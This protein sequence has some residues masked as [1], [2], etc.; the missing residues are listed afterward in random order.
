MAKRRTRAQLEALDQQIMDVCRKDHPVSVRHVFYR[1]TDP[2]LPEPVEKSG[3]GYRSVQRRVTALRRSGRLPYGWIADATRIGWHVPTFADPD[4]FVRAYASAYR[5]DLW[6]SHAPTV[7]VWT[8]SRS[9]AGVLRDV[10]REFAVSLY[11]CGG[12][13][14][15]SLS[16]AAAIQYEGPVVVLYVGDFDPAGVLIDR[17]LEREL[18][19][20]TEHEITFRRLAINENQIAEY[21]LPSKPRKG[22]DKRRLDIVATVEAE[23]MPAP[24]LRDI[25]RREIE[26]YLPEKSLDYARIMDEQGQQYLAN[27]GLY[28]TS[29]VNG[30]SG[31]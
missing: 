14:S 20:H 6:P 17:S 25:V 22:G 18:R 29:T 31:A 5:F 21:D 9:I 16:H 4:D 2:G 13:A 3:T 19:E 8:E 12:F 24:V 23:A 7:E 30:G 10:C 27:F 26:H 28:G 1:M 15:L 11:P